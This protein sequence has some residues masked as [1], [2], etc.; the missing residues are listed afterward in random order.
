MIQFVVL[1]CVVTVRRIDSAQ[2]KQIRTVVVASVVAVVV[3]VDAVVVVVVVVAVVV[4]LRGDDFND[5]PLPDELSD[6]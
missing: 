1:W 6:D 3:A 2:S 5:L 4:V